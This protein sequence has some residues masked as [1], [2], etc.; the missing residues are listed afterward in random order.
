MAPAVGIEPT[1]TPLSIN[2]LRCDNS[3]IDSLDSRQLARII[4]KWPHLSD[5]LKLAILAI[6]ESSNA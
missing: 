1:V 2:E 5:S 3:P 6:V 4:E